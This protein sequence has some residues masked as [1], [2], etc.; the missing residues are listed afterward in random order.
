MGDEAIVLFYS[1]N[2]A[3]WASHALKQEALEHKMMPI[4]RHLSS[5]C[6]YCIRLCSNEAARA[7]EILK[8]RA[9]EYDRIEKI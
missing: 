7:E 8:A 4:P 2:Y 1:H 5:D 9:I 3:I 6:G